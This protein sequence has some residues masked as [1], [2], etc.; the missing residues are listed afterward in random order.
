MWIGSELNRKKIAIAG[1]S[2]VAIAMVCRGR[3]STS[4]E[5]RIAKVIESIN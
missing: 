1:E 3:Q 2:E 4:L 5:N